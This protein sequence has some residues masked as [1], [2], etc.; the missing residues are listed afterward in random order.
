[1]GI[2]GHCEYKALL[3]QLSDGEQLP[4]DLFGSTCQEGNCYVLIH[5]SKGPT[6]SGIYGIQASVELYDLSQE[7]LQEFT[8][9]KSVLDG[10]RPLC[11]QLGPEN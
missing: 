10:L 8:H 9:Q 11:S 6:N 1:M 3:I 7:D 4:S 5:T 2:E